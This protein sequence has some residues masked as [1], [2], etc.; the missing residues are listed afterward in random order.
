MFS[1]FSA[2]RQLFNFVQVIPP[3]CVTTHHYGDCIERLCVPNGDDGAR[4]G[5][6]VQCG[7]GAYHVRGSDIWGQQA[8]SK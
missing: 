8:G 5:V 4:T 3:A 2:E 6:R 1:C 7:R